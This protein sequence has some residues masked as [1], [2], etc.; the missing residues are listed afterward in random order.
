MATLLRPLT[1]TTSLMPA[2]TASSTTSWS[3][4]T[5]TIGS[6]SFGTALVA[7]RKRVPSPAA[8]ITAFRTCAIAEDLSIAVGHRR[9]DGSARSAA[10]ERTDD[11]QLGAG[12]D[13]RVEVVLALAGDVENDVAAHPTLLVDHAEA[14]ARELAIQIDEDRVERRAVGGH[15][16]AAAGVAAE[17]RRHDDAHHAVSPAVTEYTWGRWRN[18]QWNDAPSSSLAQISPFVVPR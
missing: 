2:A 9:C 17:L 1:T 6:I 10:A 13:R 4:G 15:L 16:G 5:S 12:R 3:V 8:G 14:K 7:G 11:H 18:R